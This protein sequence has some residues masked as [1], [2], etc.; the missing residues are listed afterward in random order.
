MLVAKGTDFN[1]QINA[2]LL[3]DVLQKSTHFA[4]ARHPDTYRTLA[5]PECFTKAQI[6]EENR[7]IGKYPEGG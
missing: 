2:L 7:L 5:A 3:E 4:I 6:D 1:K